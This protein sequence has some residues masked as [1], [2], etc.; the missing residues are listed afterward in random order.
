VDG[1]CC[2]VP[3]C[4]T[5]QSCALGAA[6]TCG[7]IPNGTPDTV[8]ANACTTS[9]NGSGICKTAPG[10][11]CPAGG[12]M[13]CQNGNCVDGVCC[14]VP[15]CPTCQSCALGA[16]GTCA[17][18]PNGTPDTVP[19]NACT[20]SC[21]G[22]G[23]CKTAVG[24]ACPAGGAADC[25]SGFCADGFCCN[26]KCDSA[27]MCMTCNG[28]TPGTCTQVKGADDADSCPPATKTCDAAGAC[29]LKM[30]QPCTIMNAALCASGVCAPGVFTCL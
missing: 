4:P 13:D 15:S 20:T 24:L 25:Q 26:V 12:A 14:G 22:A 30:G 8:P 5:C 10:L 1:V 3:S 2:G 28:A 16:A 11:A 18:I 17:D 6:G 29:L 23:I 7:N 21:D 19:V 9:C 27:D